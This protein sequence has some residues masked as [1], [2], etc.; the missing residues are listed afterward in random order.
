MATLCSGL[1]DAVREDLSSGQHHMYTVLSLPVLGPARGG[2]GRCLKAD[3]RSFHDTGWPEQGFAVC[4]VDEDLSPGQDHI[5]VVFLLPALEPGKHRG[6]GAWAAD[7]AAVN[8]MGLSGH[9]YT[10]KGTLLPRMNSFCMATATSDTSLHRSSPALGTVETAAGLEGPQQ[11]CACRQS[12]LCS[13]LHPMHMLSPLTLC[14]LELCRESAPQIQGPH[15][16]LTTCAACQAPQ[17]ASGC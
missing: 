5:Y 7:A 4:A 9:S 16:H 2:A 10:A 13:C 17:S 12:W 3:H 15:R 14:A 1:R 6:R 11:P 8:L